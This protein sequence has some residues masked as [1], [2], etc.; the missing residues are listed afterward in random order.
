[1]ENAGLREEEQKTSSPLPFLRPLLR[2][3]SEKSRSFTRNI[4]KRQ[5]ANV[6]E[7]STQ[8]AYSEKR[9]RQI[10]EEEDEEKEEKEDGAGRART[11]ETAKTWN[12]SISLGESNTSERGSSFTAGAFRCSFTVNFENNVACH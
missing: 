2:E 1:M 10:T 5:R 12:I 11:R 6:S 9:S 3:A 8:T 4:K 7:A